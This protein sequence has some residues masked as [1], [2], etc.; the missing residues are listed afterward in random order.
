MYSERS[1]TK[2]VQS[3]REDAA[4]TRFSEQSFLFV[5]GSR[6]DRF[7]RALESGADAVIL[8]LEDAVEPSAKDT[9]REH[10]AN[11][12]SRRHPVLVRINGRATPWFERDARLGALD[13]VAGLVLP[14]AEQAEDVTSTVALARRRI[15][16]FPLI[17]SARGMWNA[18]EIAKA[19]FVRRLLFGTLDFIAEMGIDDDGAS[20]NHYRAQLALIS[21]VAGIETP[22]DGVTPG[23]FK[24]EAQQG[25]IEWKLR[26]S[27]RLRAYAR[28]PRMANEMH[29]WH[30]V[31][32]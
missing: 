27:K 13:G 30:E 20:L 32:C 15:P 28:R 9:S 19:P 5:P 2:V 29:V 8:D 25:V 4:T 14:K 6:P 18:M 26:L 3:T 7:E 1:K 10:V 24:S 31:G 17:E 16:V 11:W 23:G 12:V 22:V 21:R